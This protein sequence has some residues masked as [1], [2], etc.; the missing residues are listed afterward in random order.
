MKIYCRY[1]TH[2][3]SSILGKTCQRTFKQTIK[4]S[5]VSSSQ[6]R[7]VAVGDVNK[8]H[9]I[10]IVVANSGTNTIGIFLSKGDGNFEKEQTYSTGSGSRPYWIAVNDFN[11]D[12]DLDVAVA[13]YGTNNIGI[14][15]GNGNGTFVN[16]NIYS[17]G[18]SR[19]LFITIGD[20]NKDNR[21][22]I[23][24]ANYGTASVSILL[25][26][27]DGS[28]QDQI[29]YST[30]YDSI[31]TSLAVGDFNKDNHLDIAVANYGTNN[32]GIFFGYG[33][34]TFT[35]Q[36]TYTTNPNSNPSSITVTDFNNDNQLDIAVT[37]DGIGSL[38]ILL[39]QSNGSFVAQTT[40]STGFNSHPQYITVGDFNKD[41][42]SD[43]AIVDSE[44]D[45]VYVFPGFGNGSFATITTYD[46]ISGSSP[47]GIA[48]PDF[49]NNNQS[50]IVIANY[51]TNNVLVLIDYSIKPSVRQTNYNVGPS[52]SAKSVAVTDL[53]NDHI[54]DIIFSIG[55]NIFTLTGLGNGSFASEATYSI[56][57]GSVAQYI[58]V[59]DLNNDN[60]MDTVSANVNS[61]S[62]GVFLGHGDGTFAN[63]TTY[64]TGNGSSPWWLALGDVNN[65]NRLDIVSAN[66][67]ISTIGIFLGNGDGTFEIMENG[68]IH[69]DSGSYAIGIEDI[70]KDNFLDIVVILDISYLV[71]YLGNGDA[72]FNFLTSYYTYFTSYSIAFA[73]FNSDNYLDI[74]VTNIGGDNVGVFLG[75]GNG[76]F[77]KQT[78]YST[79]VGSEPYYA[80]AAD[81]NNDNI[82]DI[83]ATNWGTDEIAIFYGHGNGSFELP[84]IYSTG[85]GSKPNEIAAADLDNN[86][87][88]EI[89]V[90]LWGIGDIAVLTKYD[91]AEFVNQTIY[92]TGSASQPF[93]VATGDFNN[94]NRPDIVVANSGT[95][96]LGILL[97]S[98]NGTFD[99]DTMYLIDTDADPQYVITCDINKDNHIDIVCVNSNS[100]IISIIMGYG[101]GTFAEQMIYSTGNGSHPYAIASGDFNNDT[102]L[103]LVI[104]NEGTDSISILLGYDYASFQSQV[105]FSSNDS[106]APSGIVVSDFNNDTYLDIAATFIAANNIGFLLSC[107]NGS[108]NSMMMYSTGNGSQPYAIGVGDFNND[109]GLDIVVTNWGTQNIGVLLGYGNGSF[110]ATITSTSGD[111]SPPTAV[112][113]GD[114][115]NDDR[116]DIVVAYYHANNVEVCLGYGNGSFSVTKTYST[117]K[118]S[119]PIGVTV[120][121]IDSDSH[122]DIIVPNFGTDSV[123]ILF[124]YGNG[125]FQNQLTYSTGNE[126]WPVDI[127]VG[128]F[129]SDNRL[130]IAIPIYN[131][132][133]VAIL[134]GNGNRSFA[135]IMTYSTGTG[136]TP[137]CLRVGD[138]NNDNHLDIAVVNF[139][140]N[141]IVA[142]FGFGDGTFLLGTT[143]STGIGSQPFALAIG[144][145]NKDGRLDIA[146]AN[147]AANNIGIFF[148]N[149]SEPFG[150][151]ISYPTGDGSQPHSVAIGDLN[152]DGWSDIVTANY[153]NDNIS[154]LFGRRNGIF[155]PFMTYPTENGSAPYS[156]A[157][158]DFNSDI[159][160]DIAVTNSE[161]DSIT[162]LTGYGNGTFAIV[163][164]YSTGARS[165]PYT[166]A[167]AD[168]NNDN[169]SDIAVANSGTNNIFLLYGYGNGTF[170]NE[171]SYSLGY[172][173]LPYSIAVKDLN[174]DNWM[175]IAIACYGTDHVETLIQMC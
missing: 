67:G 91:A 149:G 137:K 46:T 142:L 139:G 37:N 19:P 111:V 62:L 65:D 35:G 163:V 102:R 125:S 4:S 154:V 112:A 150:G 100:D 86:K 57:I 61:D 11:N 138:F 89:V 157:V 136:S 84:R 110:A 99:I 7:C 85:F 16:Q 126:S 87:Q 2:A 26:Y 76:T 115:N 101:N 17:L 32:I 173:Y 82:Y 24:V 68:S 104:A 123:G 109:G 156:V 122:L 20:F 1:S 135:D 165:R 114:I 98:N 50:D 63:M 53:H 36:K 145:L 44:N 49:N 92:S 5:L 171:M 164:T 41:N 121:D 31:P 103:D 18:S 30:G 28:F 88:L 6:P 56:D 90:T 97:S 168:F 21:M 152:N 51:G 9:Q 70:N 158:A 80:I 81:F 40:Y 64:S 71:I 29:T 15:L 66:H 113:V 48:A 108:F 118:G 148:G 130:D 38:G 78:T 93:S 105:I 95:D 96:N 128:D 146:V 72:T 34:G 151:V 140:T 172:G 144:D 166:I 83:A 147:R 14:F 94:D 167:I 43:I 132:D 75:Y 134:L 73:D 162:I 39:G 58:C 33:N 153:G 107:G 69:T 133:N 143:H 23:V 52:G 124:G 174:Q 22:D 27:G 106:L 129:N 119:A 131:R 25:G 60:R 8:D 54:F 55:D 12:N 77:A 10:D 161:T 169:I 13:N 79:G 175:D 47:C 155:D 170:G 3:K 120:V 160:L 117:G 59:G 141:D 42:A 45:R 159:Y 116:L 74:V 127:T